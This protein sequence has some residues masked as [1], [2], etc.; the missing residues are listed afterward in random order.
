M[1]LAVSK[2]RVNKYKLGLKS[3]LFFE[4][5]IKLKKYR[6]NVKIPLNIDHIKSIKIIGEWKVTGSRNLGILEIQ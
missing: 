5:K 6:T 4:Q 1:Q 2:T 3:L